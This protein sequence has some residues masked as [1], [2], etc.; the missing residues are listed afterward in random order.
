MKLHSDHT[1][2]GGCRITAYGVGF[3]TVNETTFTG[4]VMLGEGEAATD[5]RE[6]RLVDLSPATIRRLREQDPEV[7]II[8]TG[9]RHIFPSSDLFSTLTHVGIGVEVMS[10]SAACRT[11]NILSAEGRKVVALLL[12]IECSE[13]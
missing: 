7:V 3:V 8:G 6:R 13:S 11:Y 10:T 4:T 1:A 2:V 5:L 9:S 12:P